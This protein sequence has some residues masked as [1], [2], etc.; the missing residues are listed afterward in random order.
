MLL[1]NL[2]RTQFIETLSR[3][4]YRFIGRVQNGFERAA[5]GTPAA[6]QESGRRTYVVAGLAAMLLVII[7]IFIFDNVF[8]EFL[9]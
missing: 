7:G 5:P 1:V 4:G 2:R 6:P 9:V 3:R 8:N